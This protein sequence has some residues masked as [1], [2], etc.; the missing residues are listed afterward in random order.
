M[1]ASP[2]LLQTRSLRVDIAGRTICD[3]LNF[4]L[5]RGECWGILGG[6]GIGK[7]TLLR[8]LAGLRSDWHGEILVEGQDL[9][10]WKRK[11]L[12][13]RLGMLFQ[14]SMDVFP[15][16]VLETVLS[17]RY[18]YIPA[19]AMEGKED[20]KIAMQALSA[21][22]LDQMQHRQVDSLSGGERRRLAIA[23][24]IVQDPDIWLLDEPTNHLDLHHQVTLLEQVLQRVSE[25]NGAVMMVM[26][27]IN[28]L[29]RFCSHAML[30][31]NQEN[32]IC[33]DLD[34]VL[35][36][37]NLSA[38]YRHPVKRITQ[39]NDAFFYPA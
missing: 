30:M 19:F 37:E 35:T 13:Q 23:T 3:Q 32:I 14:D 21:V 15:V 1:N 9:R 34:T 18:P 2:E 29:T 24:L 16:T 11:P 8:T 36:T 5:K 33:G 7:T 17:G 4:K 12:A 27:D 26:H 22:E 25:H 38:L 39:G 6:N 28:L 20:R 31:V 10:R